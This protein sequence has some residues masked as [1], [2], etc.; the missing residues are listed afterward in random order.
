MKVQTGRRLARSVEGSISISTSV[1]HFRL[2]K[3]KVLIHPALTAMPDNDHPVTA[4]RLQHQA[5]DKPA[6]LTVKL[7]H[8][9]EVDVHQ[10]LP[11]FVV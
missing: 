3:V 1:A 11:A 5:H 6:D 9:S 2:S 8:T 4:S 7:P 10:C